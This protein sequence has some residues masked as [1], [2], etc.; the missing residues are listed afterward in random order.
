MYSRDIAISA[1][2]LQNMFLG[3]AKYRARIMINCEIS[4]TASSTLFFMVPIK[5]IVLLASNYE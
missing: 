4:M 1:K 2:D 3:V 5:Y